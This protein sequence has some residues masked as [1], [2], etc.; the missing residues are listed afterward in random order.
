[1]ST[2]SS[3]F[4]IF[5]D[6]KGDDM[7]SIRTSIHVPSLVTFDT[8]ALPSSHSERPQK[9]IGGIGHNSDGSNSGVQDDPFLYPNVP[10]NIKLYATIVPSL[11]TTGSSDSNAPLEDPVRE[12]TTNLRTTINV[13]ES[14]VV[15]SGTLEGLVERLITNFSGSSL[16]SAVSMIHPFYSKV[17]PRT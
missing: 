10:S 13:T 5:K 15:S 17:Y 11:R 12:A 1:M 16:G 9:I 2:L 6:R 4:G 8:A 3:A 7:S 14:G